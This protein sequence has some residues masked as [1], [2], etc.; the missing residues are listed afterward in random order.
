MSSSAF[1]SKAQ[2]LILNGDFELITK[3]PNGVNMQEKPKNLLFVTN[4]NQGSFDLFHECDDDKYPRYQWGNQEPQNGKGFVG[5]S[6]F[7]NTSNQTNERGEYIQL[8]LKDS[9]KEGNIYRFEMFLSLADK[10]HIAI[11]KL[12]IYFSNDLLLLKTDG[13]IPVKPDIVSHDFY[14]NK[15]GWDK[16]T[17]DYIA[18]GGEKYIVIGNFRKNKYVETKVVD[19]GP[20]TDNYVYYFIDN[21]SLKLNT[22][23]ADGIT[24]N[25]VNFKKGSSELLSNSFSE[26]NKIATVLEVNP[27]YKLEIVGH[28]DNSGVETSNIKLSKERAMAVQRYLI[29]R[30]VSSSR[31]KSLGM[32]SRESIQDNSTEQGKEKNRRVEFK[33]L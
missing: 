19:S 1:Y 3:C 15:T 18:K 23:L 30:G 20:T 28:T 25:N 22:E 33:F 6:V 9:L 31:I 32:G 29:E 5:I 26:L 17:G 12:G 11:N 4:P 13:I 27:N 21:V 8:E 10:W 2:N 24:F 14:S 16:F 7:M